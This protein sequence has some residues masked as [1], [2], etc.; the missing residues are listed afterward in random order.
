MEGM[1]LAPPAERKSAS[2]A[3]S[4][5]ANDA[6]PPSTGSPPARSAT[7]RLVSL[8]AYRGFIM[9]MLASSGFG[10]VKLAKTVPSPVTEFLAGQ[11]Q[12]VAWRG[13]AFWDLIQP[14]FMFMVGVS[15]PFSYGAR[16]ARGATWGQMLWHALVR[17]IILVFLGLLLASHATPAVNYKF[18][19]VLAQIGLGYTF[20]FLIWSLGPTVQSLAIV[21][22]LASYGWL[23][24]QHPLPDRE[25]WPDDGVTQQDS[26]DGAIIEGPGAPWSKGINFAAEQDRRFLNLFP[27]NKPFVFDAGGYQTLNFVPSLAT[28]LLGVLA[29][30]LLRSS[31]GAR[32]RILWLVVG[33]AVCLAAGMALDMTVLPS[34]KRIWTPSW[35]LVSGAWTLWMLAAF[36]AV[37]DV[38]G[39]WRWSM[40][41]VVVGCN[42]IVMYLMSQLIDEWIAGNVRKVA[43]DDAFAGDYGPLM[44]SASVVAVE[45][46]VCVWLYRQK[47]FVRI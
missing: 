21:A 11:M 15:M 18:T 44:L 22:I 4:T 2:A 26:D 27:R 41:L 8:D 30:E 45:W 46:L 33:G 17:S 31:V 39:W 19:N 36:Y 28:M 9:L 47:L 40:P 16:R 3:V 5:A 12:H 29:G 43:G 6:T 23:F 37:I 25:Q 1:K 14:A 24:Y 13:Y 7:A 10:L 34:V 38:G 42:S 35:V 20:L 32:G